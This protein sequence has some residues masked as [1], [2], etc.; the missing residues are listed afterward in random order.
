MYISNMTELKA[1][2][3]S[4]KTPAL[5]TYRCKYAEIPQWNLRD[6]I[7]P[8]W[9]C[10]LPVSRGGSIIYEDERIEL[11]PGR[12]YMIPPYT[13]FS[14]EM[15]KPFC[16]AYSH[17]NF[18][19]NTMGFSPGIYCFVPPEGLYADIQNCIENR[20]ENA[21]WD[22]WMHMTQLCITGL[23]NIPEENIKAL[24]SDPRLMK[25]VK[26]MRSN[27]STP[28]PNSKLA[29][30]V[31]M[32]ENSFVRYFRMGI[33][34]APQKYY[35]MLR[36]EHATVLLVSSDLSIEEIAAQCGFWD[37]NHFSKVFSGFWNCPPAKFRK[38]E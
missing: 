38:R 25:I 27:F 28:L 29:K 23:L 16:K 22:F 11:L 12:A 13:R 35:T 31:N 21:N 6:M 37:R 14:T 9:R 15:Y 32:H 5:H 18:E 36:M 2:I 34:S 24:P 33:G 20:N 30:S 3:D 1:I 4:V 8:W 17:F 19:Y 7:S 10:Y 26:L